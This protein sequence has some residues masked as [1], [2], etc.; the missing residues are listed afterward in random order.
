MTEGAP[1]GCTPPPR[2]YFDGAPAIGGS[3]TAR[4]G[5]LT[6]DSGSGG[7]MAEGGC[8]Y[9]L[10]LRRG[11][12]HR[13]IFDSTSGSTDHGFR[14]GG[15]NGGRGR[16]TPSRWSS[17]PA[18]TSTELSTSGPTQGWMYASAHAKGALA[19]STT[20]SGGG[21]TGGGNHL[22]GGCLPSRDLCV[23]AGCIVC[24]IQITQ[25]PPPLILR[26]PQHER[27]QP[28]Q[29]WLR[30]G[31]IEG[32]GIGHRLSPFPSGLYKGHA[33]AHAQGAL[34]ASA[35]HRGRGDW[36]PAATSRDWG[37]LDW[38]VLFVEGVGLLVGVGG[39]EDGGLGEVAT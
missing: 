26:E 5:P 31:P 25:P 14:L 29:H 23:T 13:R 11:S 24:T 17:P 21:M 30:K 16:V 3:S 35:T 28:L 39:V 36:T 15:W 2:S 18:H 4:A 10:I 37:C 32:E 27:P 19:A 9:P 1:S 20:G 22:Y 12:R 34:A 33:S 7:G 6:M 8:L 38:W